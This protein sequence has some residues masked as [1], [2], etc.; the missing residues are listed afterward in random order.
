MSTTEDMK[1]MTKVLLEPDEWE[2]EIGTDEN[3]PHKLGMKV[4]GKEL[5]H[6]HDG[7]PWARQVIFPEG[8]E[9]IA[10]FH[11]APQ[12]QVVL[13]GSVSFPT[14]ELVAPAVHYA[15]ALSP[16][17]PFTCGKGFRIMV[18]RPWRAKK[19]NMKDR[20]TRG[21]RDPY[22]RNMY[23]QSR[24]LFGQV[25][26]NSLVRN[27]GYEAEILLGTEDTDRLVEPFVD[28]VR[29]DAGNSISNSSVITEFGLF[30]IVF[31]GALQIGHDK[32]EPYSSYFVRGVRGDS[33]AAGPEGATFLRLAFDQQSDLSLRPAS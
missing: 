4:L 30:V 5:A 27:D 17:G 21:L 31:K 19:Y 9:N 14:H 26:D 32:L 15:D 28:L 13:E 12:F 3:Q 33:L 16:Y 7:G 6:G 29:L 10:H 20:E 18:V 2:V 8:F 1:A 25:G 22:G 11:T 23:G 24:Q